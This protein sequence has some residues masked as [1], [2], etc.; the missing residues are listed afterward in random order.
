MIEFLFGVL[1]GFVFS[2]VFNY[3]IEVVDKNGRR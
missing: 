2:N 1:I 3:I